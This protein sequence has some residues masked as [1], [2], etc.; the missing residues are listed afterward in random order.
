MRNLREESYKELKDICDQYQIEIPT[1]DF[2]KKD[3]LPVLF[4]KSQLL[5]LYER[6]IHSAKDIGNYNMEE[7]GREYSYDTRLFNSIC[8]VIKLK[9]IKALMIAS[10]DEGS[11]KLVSDFLNVIWTFQSKKQKCTFE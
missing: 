9:G 10:E 6:G 11:T 2:L 5:T 1:L 8:K 7:L 3:L 4:S